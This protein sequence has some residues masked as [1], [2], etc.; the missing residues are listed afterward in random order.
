MKENIWL[1]GKRYQA[2]KLLWVTKSNM[3]HAK[4]GIDAFPNAFERV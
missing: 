2:M 1:N 3:D 4:K